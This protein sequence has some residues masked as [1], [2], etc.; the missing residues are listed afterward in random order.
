MILEKMIFHF[1]FHFFE[2]ANAEAAP[3]AYQAD[4]QGYPRAISSRAQVSAR[5]VV[6]SGMP[7]APCAAAC[8]GK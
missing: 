5:T 7:G 1:I 4:E 2:E 6:S 3:P 8:W